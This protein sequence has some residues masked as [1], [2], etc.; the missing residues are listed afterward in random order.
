MK[1]FSG[2]L[3]TIASI[4]LIV[5][6]FISTV[7]ISVMDRNYYA[8]QY[9]LMETSRITH[10]PHSDL[11]KATNQLLDYLA[12]K[13]D[14]AN[15]TVKIKNKERN[16]FRSREMEHMTDVR[17]LYQNAMFLRNICLLGAIGLY[18]FSLLAARHDRLTV[19]SQG[20]MRAFIIIGIVIAALVIWMAIDFQSFW[21]AFH[22]LLFRNDLWQ[23]DADTSVMITMFPLAFWLVL[24]KRIALSVAVVCGGLLVLCI[25]YQIYRAYRKRTFLSVKEQ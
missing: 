8:T 23:L 3:A 6:I 21:N 25:G 2:F 1:G 22:H 19:I 5:G 7:Q 12:G 18:L 10:I 11:M 13:S 16:I 14:D 24:C 20:Y 15:A 9:R 17:D 4:L